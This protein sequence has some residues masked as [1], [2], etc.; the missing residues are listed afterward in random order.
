MSSPADSDDVSGLACLGG[1][2]DEAGA[3][4][5]RRRQ[6]PLALR[7]GTLLDATHAAPH[8]AVQRAAHL[9]TLVQGMFG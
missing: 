2:V 4:A 6:D 1:V 9:R 8:D 7:R 3:V 5:P